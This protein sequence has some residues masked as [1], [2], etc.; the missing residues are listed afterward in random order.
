M[1]KIMSR[2]LA[3]PGFNKIIRQR[4]DTQGIGLQF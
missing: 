3:I 2:D 4:E 1:P